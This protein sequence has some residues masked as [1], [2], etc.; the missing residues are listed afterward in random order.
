MLLR[1]QRERVRVD[2][3]RR[4]AA[5]VLE[6]LHLVEV[7]ALTLSEPV[8]AVELDL[9]DLHGVLALAAHTRVEDDLGEQ[10][11]H[12]RL[13]LTRTGNVI[14]VDTHKRRLSNLDTTQKGSRGRYT[15]RRY[16]SVCRYRIVGT[17]SHRT[18]QQTH[19]ETLRGEVVGVVE[20]L[21]ATD[22]CNPGRIRAVH[23][24]VALDDP[25][26]LLHGVIEVQLDL[27]GRAGDALRARVLHLLDEVL[28][29]LLGETA[30]LLR[31]EVHVVNVQRRG[32]ERL[33]GRSPR[34]A[35]GKLS[36]RAVLPRLEVDVD[37]HLV[38]LERDQRDRQTRVAAEPE[39]ERDVQR[40]G[41]RAAA[42]HARDG[43]LRRRAHRIQRN[44]RGALHQRQVVRLANDGV[45]RRHGA[46]LR[47][48][49]GPDLHPVTVLAINALAANLDLNLLDEAVA[50]VREP[51]ETLLGVAVRESAVSG[52]QVNLGKHNLNVRLVHEIGVAV[53]HSRYALVEIGLAVEGDFNG[54][55]GEV[56]MALVQHLP[57]GDL[58]VAR[59]VN[60]LRA[61]RHELHKTT[62]HI[63]FML[64]YEKKFS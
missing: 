39:L 34:S 58:G 42:G 62:T 12:T 8:L 3:H 30:A 33:G 23:E 36:V 21:G 51:A 44:A 31:V 19:D 38:V 47:G 61:I 18:G 60:V 17:T 1:A 53:N 43:R 41:R 57:E 27:V 49:L 25:E 26:Q 2:T 32:R 5:V 22:R 15:S 54:L 46:R 50:N 45:Q 40:L 64:Y 55:H 37:A 9:G 29:A 7:G 14:R 56:G 35:G 11:V 13:E 20:G 28:V 4:R 48:E 16:I 59:D 6:G 52:S 24:R 63:V 10:V